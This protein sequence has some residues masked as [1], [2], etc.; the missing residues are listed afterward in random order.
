MSRLAM[1]N[2]DGKSRPPLPDPAGVR[3]DLVDLRLR[4]LA[5]T[6][7]DRL[8]TDLAT[9]DAAERALA[10]GC[11]A[12]LVD[13]FA[14][15]GLD[16]IRALTP[17]PVLGAGE[18]SIA[19]AADRG[20]FS[21]VTVWP[22]SMGFLYDERL[23]SCAGG[24]ECAGV[25]HVS[26]EGELDLLGTPDGVKARMTRT[27]RPVVEQL[28]EACRE[29][30]R[31]DGSDLVLLG[32]TC[33]APVAGLIAAQLDVE[34]LDPSRL[35]QQAAFDA[36]RSG[37]RPAAGAPTARAGDVVRLLDAWRAAEPEPLVD[38]CDVCV[39]VTTG[40]ETTETTETTET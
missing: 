37:P 38:D 3:T 12:L 4:A 18:S 7:Y 15:Y 35:G 16:A 22:A 5:R 9:V 26:P 23:A 19:A 11:E 30:V 1:L 10:D 33:M 25:H 14:D 17:V 2:C 20:R 29:A 24:E 36:L 34:V 39:V 32:C 21:V 40:P 28:V 8:L 31:R 13:S 6:P 27:E